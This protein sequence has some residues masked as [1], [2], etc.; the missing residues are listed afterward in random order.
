MWHVLAIGEM[1]TGFW[2]KNMRERANWEGIG[3]D[4]I[5]MFKFIFKM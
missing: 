3:V 4:E 1:H 5:R 2:W